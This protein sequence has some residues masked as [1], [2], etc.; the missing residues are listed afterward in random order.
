MLCKRIF[1]VSNC[2]RTLLVIMSNVIK[3]STGCTLFILEL[4]IYMVKDVSI[5]EGFEIWQSEIYIVE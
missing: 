2:T 4:L 5:Y 1:Y 3:W